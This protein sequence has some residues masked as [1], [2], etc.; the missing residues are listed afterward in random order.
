MCHLALFA[1]WKHGMLNNETLFLTN[2]TCNNSIIKRWTFNNIHDENRLEKILNCILVF[3][4]HNVLKKHVLYG[5]SIDEIPTFNQDMGLE[6]LLS[7]WK[8][9]ILE[10]A[11]ILVGQGRKFISLTF[12]FFHFFQ[13]FQFFHDFNLFNWFLSK[14]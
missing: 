7:P 1:F 2:M 12:Y 10:V 6:G 14:F 9:A 8:Y 4:F 3:G 5:C 13:F 11:H